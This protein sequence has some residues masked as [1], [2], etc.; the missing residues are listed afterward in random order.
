MLLIADAALADACFYQ[1]SDNTDSGDGFRHRDSACH[2]Q[3]IDRLWSRFDLDVR[4]WNQGVR[5]DSYNVN[6]PSV[7]ICK[8]LYLPVGSAS[9]IVESYGPS[10]RDGTIDCIGLQD[11][12]WVLEW[13]LASLEFGSAHDLA[14]SNQAGPLFI[15]KYAI[16]AQMTVRFGVFDPDGGAVS[17]GLAGPDGPPLTNN[18]FIRW[19]GQDLWSTGLYA[20]VSVEQPFA[21]HNTGR[22]P[23]WSAGIG[24]KRAWF[25][26]SFERVHVDPAVPTTADSTQYQVALTMRPG[27]RWDAYL[28]LAR[29][30]GLRSASQ[31]LGANYA[32]RS[33]LDLSAE[34]SNGHSAL[35]G[36]VRSIDVQ[37]TFKF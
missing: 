35:A 9:N 16:N 15:G 29:C 22:G 30:T 32:L 4:D 26:V 23:Y 37:L 13:P 20:S 33:F 6:Q 17:R 27:E 36:A 12:R 8:P 31:R 11:G 21:T 3:Y 2:Q 28:D 1:S 18:I 10:G 7:R 25:D 34:I 5:H 24:V 14:G 19:Q